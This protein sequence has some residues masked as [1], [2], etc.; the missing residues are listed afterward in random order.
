MIFPNIFSWKAECCKSY[1]DPFKR[2]YNA[3]SKDPSL[4]KILEKLM[5]NR[6]MKFLTEQKIFYLEQFGFRKTFSTAHAIINLIDS[7]KNAID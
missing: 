3:P 4:D 7:I 2:N 5:K 1:P 6:L